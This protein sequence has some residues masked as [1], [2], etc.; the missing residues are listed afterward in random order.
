MPVVSA[1]DDV[2]INAGESVTLY[3][4]GGNTYLWSTGET[5]A[6]ISVSPIETTTYTITT[7]INGCSDTDEV[8][9]IVISPIEASA[10]E[11]IT[12]CNG[13]TAVLTATGGDQFEWSTGETTQSIDVN[14]SETKV[15]TVRVSNSYG[16]A[17]DDVQVNVN[18]CSLDGP[19]EEVTGFD[20]SIFP[21][22]SDG[23]LNIKISN[24][25][26]DGFIYVTDIIGKR[27]STLTIESGVGQVIRRELNLSTMPP[28]FYILNFSTKNRSITKKIILR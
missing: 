11:D 12:I 5:N 10:G 25:D 1:G 3:G 8:T 19:P 22:P 7:T 6:N 2:T 24:L 21:N 15:Y 18:D 27:I 23:V 4:S 20:F 16:S 9:V 14:P 26:L 17:I 13:E 28:G